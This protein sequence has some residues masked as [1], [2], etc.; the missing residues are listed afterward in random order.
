M[1]TCRIG[2]FFSRRP[3][4]LCSFWLH[5]QNHLFSCLAKLKNYMGRNLQEGSCKSDSS[6][7]L[8]HIRKRSL[9]S[10]SQTV[11]ITRSKFHSVHKMNR[12]YRHYPPPNKHVPK[13]KRR[14]HDFFLL[15]SILWNS[16]LC[17]K[18]SSFLSMYCCLTLSI[19]FLKCP[20]QMLSPLYCQP[21]MCLSSTFACATSTAALQ[22]W[23]DVPE[24]QLHYSWRRN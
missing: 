3:N 1:I 23:H 18:V 19:L 5:L 4:R 17:H 8:L 9:V 24:T 11:Y 10:L 22:E 16:N 21:Y 6:P 13:L 7:C 15:F 20:F 14:K 2:I 12:I